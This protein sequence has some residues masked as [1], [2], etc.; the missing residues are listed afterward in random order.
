MKRITGEYYEYPFIK[1]LDKL[2]E[3]NTFLERQTNK[4]NPKNKKKSPG[5]DGFNSEF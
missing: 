5:P 2:G 3:M 1:N 4:M